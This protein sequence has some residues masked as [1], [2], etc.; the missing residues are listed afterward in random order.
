MKQA[1]GGQWVEGELLGP[2]SSPGST[3]TAGRLSV[4]DGNEE[5]LAGLLS[6]PCSQIHSGPVL[7]VSARDARYEPRPFNS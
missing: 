3:S 7:F 5:A 2:T 4:E 1:E 6:V